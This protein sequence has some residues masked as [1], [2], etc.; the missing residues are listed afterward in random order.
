MSSNTPAV[1]VPR[2][3]DSS[4]S[5]GVHAQ[6]MA[7]VLGTGMSLASG[8]A[9]AGDNYLRVGFGL[10]LPW[11]AVFSDTDCSG[12]IGA[13]LYGC[14]TGKDGEPTRSVGKFESVR[15]VELG[16]GYASGSKR[17]EMLVEY[18]PNFEFRGRTNFLSADRRQD[19]RAKLSTVS[20]MLAGFIDL[21]GVGSPKVGQPIPFFGA[22]VGFAHTR[23]GK[24]SIYF[25]ATTTIVPGGSRT[26]FAWMAT[27]GIAVALDDRMTVDLAWRYTDLGKVRT[28]QG[29][30][31]VVWRDGSQGPNQ[32]N[33]APTESRLRGLGMSLSLRY[34][35]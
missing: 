18:R 35:F 14:G 33:L 15:A 25:P 13:A 16:F 23:I 28:G 3:D 34:S 11:N 7:L 1:A 8:T 6:L 24:T 27:T 30:G 26:G 19:V 31:Q 17:L 21:T 10:D 12:A 5:V 4:K 32:L 9:V 2:I 29:S 22:G 20:A